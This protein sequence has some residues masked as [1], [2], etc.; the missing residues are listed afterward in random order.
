MGIK[1]GYWG[2]ILWIDLTAR[3]TKIETFDNEFARKYMGGV[4]FSAKIVSDHVTMDVD[5]LSS[6]NVLIFSTGPFQASRVSGSGRIA[7]GSRSPLTGYWGES[8]CGAHAGPAM[9]RAGYDC[10]VITGKDSKPVYLSIIDDRIEF[11]DAESLWA[12]ADAIETVDKI[13][14]ELKEKKN[15]CS[16]NRASR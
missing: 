14:E 10:V 13:K 11:H 4:G 3:N 9:K 6:S 12:K 16:D 7:V 1:G 5:P 8:S 2:K 15:K